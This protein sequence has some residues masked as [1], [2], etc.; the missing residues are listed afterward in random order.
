MN[1]TSSPKAAELFTT[2]DFYC[3]V[4]EWRET[5]LR[6]LEPIRMFGELVSVSSPL[7]KEWR[8]ICSGRKPRCTTVGVYFLRREAQRIAIETEDVE[9][10]PGGQP[11]SWVVRFTTD[12]SVDFP[13]APFAGVERL[14]SEAVPTTHPTTAVAA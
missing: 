12:A 5:G 9:P 10:A 4:H 8:M 11:N 6:R 13:F 2:D 7:R 1:T 3:D 14:D